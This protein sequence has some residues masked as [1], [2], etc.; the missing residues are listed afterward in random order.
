MAISQASETRERVTVEAQ[1]GAEAYAS[2]L[3]RAVSCRRLRAGERSQASQ[4]AALSR[5][6]RSAR[7]SRSGRSLSRVGRWI[8]PPFNRF[9]ASSIATGLIGKGA[10]IFELV[11][12]QA[13]A[14]KA[15][16]I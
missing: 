11:R 14:Q 1:D 13:E 2:I 4:A 7:R 8:V 5:S 10:A 15:K 9:K 6:K 3:I 16:A 12:R